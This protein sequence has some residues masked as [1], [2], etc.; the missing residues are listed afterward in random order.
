[1]RSRVPVLVLAL[2]GVVLATTSACGGDD[3]EPATGPGLPSQA[4]LKSYFEAI[5]SGDADDAA[6]ARADVAAPGSPAEG[7]AAYIEETDRA[8]AA[9]GQES[10]AVEVDEVD[11]G[12]KACIAEGKCV[13]WSDLKGEDGRLA[14][15]SV[16]GVTLEESLVDLTA[17]SP[18]SSPGLYDVQPEWAYRLPNGILN[19]VV[20]VTASDVPLAPRP[21]TYIESDQILKGAKDVY[22]ATIDA[23]TSSPVVLSFPGADKTKLDGQVTFE[24]KLGDQGT[25]PIGFGLAD[26]ATS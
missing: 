20:I 2:S 6:A 11:N 12:F 3:P 18:V 24:L 4:A 10:D 15:F 17:Q 8:T 25:E 21:G 19:V 22:P 5:T 23:G 9:D 14:T 16:S 26:P 13:T 7:Y 1:V